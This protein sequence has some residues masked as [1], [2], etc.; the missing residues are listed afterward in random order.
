LLFD[1]APRFEEL[2]FAP[3][4]ELLLED[5]AAFFVVP[6]V[7]DFDVDVLP[8]GDDFAFTALFAELDDLLP[9]LFFDEVLAAPLVLLFVE[10]DFAFEL[11]D[12]DV[13]DFE[14]DD[15]EVDD[16]FVDAFF[17]VGMFSSSSLYISSK[18]VRELVC[19]Q[20]AASDQSR[21][22]T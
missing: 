21:Y 2:D 10:A 11:A 6:D 7:F 15:R 5:V 8:D 3:D 13:P 12:F 14:A 1:F 22:V 17:V 18:V 9:E 4:D 20:Y 19:N 16:F